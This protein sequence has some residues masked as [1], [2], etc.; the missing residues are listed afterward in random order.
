MCQGT[1]IMTDANVNKPKTITCNT[2][3][4]TLVVCVGYA[5]N[6]QILHK[7]DYTIFLF[8][9]STIEYTLSNGAFQTAYIL[10]YSIRHQKDAAGCVFFKPALIHRFFLK[11]SQHSCSWGHSKRQ[12][13]KIRLFETETKSRV[14]DTSMG[15]V[16]WTCSS[17][18]PLMHKIALN[19][20]DVCPFAQVLGESESSSS[21]VRGVLEPQKKFG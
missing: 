11:I 9:R 1:P 5:S 13:N 17:I 3:S 14:D 16:L 12:A 7:L 2:E 6:Q 4:Q 18:T 8:T 21:G 20:L 10:M 15:T 19:C